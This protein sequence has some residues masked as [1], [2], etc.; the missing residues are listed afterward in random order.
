MAAAL[1]NELFDD[2]TRLRSNVRGRGKDKLDPKKIEYVK[3]KCFDMFP[4]ERDGDMKKD[5]E[6]CIV[7]I[8]DKARELKHK[9]KKQQAKQ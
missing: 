6:D 1:V 8:D 9:L 3:K 2:E 4:S 5:W 7:C